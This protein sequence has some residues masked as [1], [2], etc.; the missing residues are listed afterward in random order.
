MKKILIVEDHMMTAENLAAVCEEGG[1]QAYLAMSLIEAQSMIKE[2]KFQLIVWDYNLPDG[3]T[4]ELIRAAR[5]VNPEA[6]MIAAS[7]NPDS[8]ELQL[9]A[10][11]NLSAN[12]YSIY[13]LLEEE[14]NKL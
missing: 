7:S 5:E 12:P 11:C 14:V 9:K 6:T 2:K 10:G 4:L 8:R 3:T 1:C 13:N